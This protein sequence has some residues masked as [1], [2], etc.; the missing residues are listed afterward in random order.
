MKQQLK[1]LIK[2]QTVESELK[3]IQSALNAIPEKMVRLD[4]QLET[5]QQTVESETLSIETTK[6]A[7]RDK[8]LDVQANQSKIQDNQAKMTAVKTNKEYQAL[9]KGIDD[10]KKRNHAIE[11]EMLLYLEEM[12]SKEE[13]I[14]EKKQD[15]A[16]LE[17]RVAG[18]KDALE[19]ENASLTVRR[20]QLAAEQ[21]GIAEKLNPD[22]AGMFNQV[23]GR[24][25]GA[26]VV[27]VNDAICNGCY[28]NIPPQM[29]NDLQR[30]NSLKLC[31]HCDRIIYWDAD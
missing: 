1:I 9:L 7:Y 2:L 30:G 6:C 22:I 23:K 10:L 15:L 26:A 13:S 24:V 18:D 31:P 5:L 19:K 16:T 17:V 27:P 12:E 14:V 21:G 3:K 29:Y 8:E 4:Q 28:L 25:K 20:S 11:D